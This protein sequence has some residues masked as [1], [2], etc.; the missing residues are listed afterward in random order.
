MQGRVQC[1]VVVK[2]WWIGGWGLAVGAS[3][4]LWVGEEK[5]SMTG[6]AA[7]SPVEV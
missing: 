1:G 2:M 3:G 6:K 4:E 7:G 5:K